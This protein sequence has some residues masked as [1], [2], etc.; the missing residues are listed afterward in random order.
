M[1]AISKL[2]YLRQLLSYSLLDSYCLFAVVIAR[3]D[4]L[5]GKLHAATILAVVQHGVCFVV[6][7][8]CSVVVFF[9]G[10]GVCLRFN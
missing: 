9:A 10:E 1:V 3:V 8:D 6:A 5:A 7:D 4:C 2:F